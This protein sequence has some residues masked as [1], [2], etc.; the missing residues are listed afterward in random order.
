MSE[1]IIHPNVMDLGITNTQE[2]RTFEFQ[3]KNTTGQDIALSAGASCGCS[4]P[5]VVPTVVPANGKA[6][7]VVEFDPMGKSGMQEKNV[8]VEYRINGERRV[9]TVTFRTQITK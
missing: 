1:I 7:L 2:P 8:W 5:S 3:I 6:R 4:L 9:Q